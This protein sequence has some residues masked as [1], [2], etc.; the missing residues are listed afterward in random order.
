MIQLT[1]LTHE[2]VLVNSDLIVLVEAN[3]DTVV[4]LTTGERVRVLEGIR[5]IA[6]R[7]VEFKGRVMRE[8]VV[9]GS[10]SHG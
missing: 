3:P 6:E 2:D 5:D 8:A 4:T 9:M 1:R 7:V 10:Q